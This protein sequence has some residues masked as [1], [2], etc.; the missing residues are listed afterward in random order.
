MVD[1]T[2]RAAFLGQPVPLPVE[3]APA[4]WR[5]AASTIWYH[6]HAFGYTR[7]NVY[8]GLAG[9]YIIRDPGNE[10]AGLPSGSYEAFSTRTL[11]ASPPASGRRSR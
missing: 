10:P 5:A 4:D 3:V 7:H 9:Y 2:K 1:Y 8:A 11:T 6:D